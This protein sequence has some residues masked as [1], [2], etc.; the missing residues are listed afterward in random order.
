[1]VVELSYTQDPNWLCVEEQDMKTVNANLLFWRYRLSKQSGFMLQHTSHL[2][3]QTELSQLVSLG[4]LKISQ[5]IM[6]I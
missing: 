4:C 2:A 6:T 1:M 3:Y 5:Q